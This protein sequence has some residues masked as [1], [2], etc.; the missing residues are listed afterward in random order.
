MGTKYKALLLGL[1]AVV[2]TSTNFTLQTY[3]FGSGADSSGSSSYKLQASSGSPADTLSSGSYQ[4]PAGIRASAS[5]ARPLAP[6]ITNPDSSYNRL[7]IVL[8]VNGMPADATFLVAISSDNFV[9]TNY[10][11]TD[12]TISSSA[13]IGNYQ[14]YS[15]WGGASGF[16]VLG[17]SYN[18]TYK[19][20]VAALQG[21]ATGSGFGPT[22]SATTSTPSVTFALATSATSTPPF[23]IGFGSLTPGTVVSGDATIIT[24]ITTNAIGGGAVL[25]KS[26]HAGLQSVSTASS[27][28]GA[29]VTTASQSSGGPLAA[30]S[31]FDGNSDSVG[32]LT[33][34]WQQLASFGGSIN[35]GS[36]IAVLKAKAAGD[37]KA[38]TDYGDVLTFS[39]SLLF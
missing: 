23:S 22:A 25:V 29:Q 36:L 39:V 24:N 13:G 31:P 4:L 16:W 1:L 2:P 12:Q 17:L 35:G 20:K 21:A 6:A 19:V 26:Q 30:S 15:S 9:T 33:T 18:T 38:A 8:N 28:Y 11:Q 5:V 37:I 3:D 7:K 27:G 34:T 32:A 14:T 10:V